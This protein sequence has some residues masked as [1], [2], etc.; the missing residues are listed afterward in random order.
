MLTSL[1]LYP[2]GESNME[3]SVPPSD[4]RKLP[5]RQKI[6]L[7]LI[8]T[9]C[10]TVG[11]A[12][13]IS[14]SEFSTLGKAFLEVL[15][16]TAGAVGTGL[17]AIAA[18]GSGRKLLGILWALAAIGLALLAIPAWGTFI[19]LFTEYFGA[20]NQASSGSYPIFTA[21]NCR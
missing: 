2:D 14:E 9:G 13:G 15:F 3:Q 12:L 21:Y 4:I 19:Q 20:H 8:I 16:T 17:G 10:I 18:I 5:R 7:A 11:A 1:C 6:K